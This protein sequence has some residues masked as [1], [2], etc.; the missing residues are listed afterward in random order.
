MDQDSN[1]FLGLR[2]PDP[3]TIVFVRILILLTS[4]KGR[5]TF[6]STIFFFLTLYLWKTD[7][8][9]LLKSNKKKKLSFCWHLVSH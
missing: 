3:F 4:K 8:N 7:V 9:V 2:D 1:M 6:N 5:K